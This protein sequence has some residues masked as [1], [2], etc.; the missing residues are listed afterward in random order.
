MNGLLIKLNKLFLF[1]FI[2]M[3]GIQVSFGCDCDP[4][5]TFEDVSKTSK[6]VVLAKVLGFTAMKE[7]N[8]T[9]YHLKPESQVKDTV[10]LSMKVEILTL[11]NGDELRDTITLWGDYGN[12]CRPYLNKFEVGNQYIFALFVGRN[13]L[14]ENYGESSDDYYVTNCGD[15]WMHYDPF[16]KKGTGLSNGIKLEYTFDEL[17]DLYR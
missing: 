16:T 17:I 8:Y 12:L 14:A 5:P 3:S 6:I 7:I 11:F 15:G 13:F 9:D 1:F 2:L 10:P 4:T